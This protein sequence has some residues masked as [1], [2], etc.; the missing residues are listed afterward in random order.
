M[1][2]RFIRFSVLAW[3]AVF[4]LNGEASEVASN[5][6]SRVS[7]A[8]FADVQSAYYA[9]GAIV[10]KRPFSAQFVNATVSLAEDVRVGG[11]AWSVSSMSQS[12]QSAKR[13]YA[14]NEVDYNLYGEYD[15]E[16]YEGWLLRNRMALQWVTLEGYDPHANTV[17]EWH[18]AQS[19]E[20]PYVTPYYLLR[21][22][23]DQV[24]WCYW[25]AGLRRTFEL[26][27]TVFFTLQF[28]GDL[29]DDRHFRS[30]YGL[31]PGG[32]SYGHGL[33]ALNFMARIDWMLT[34]NFGL[35]AFVHQ[36][37]IVSSAGRD[38]MEAS[39]APESRTDMTIGGVGVKFAF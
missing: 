34:D 38:A 39:T 12:G 8:A 3:C 30:Q 28:F 16:F 5:L 21:R 20:N 31:R 9:R 25:Q 23:Y 11:Y 6:A 37:D 35:Y 33:M 17:F 29:G 13:R 27:D 1:K 4:C 26:S 19:I 24:Q 22:A 18:A 14:Y 2:H 10:D 7:V 32:G 15:F 36:F